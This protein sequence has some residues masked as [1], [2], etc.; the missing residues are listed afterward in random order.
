MAF[1]DRKLRKVERMSDAVNDFY[2]CD[3]CL[4]PGIT[5]PKG[6]EDQARREFDAH[7][8]KDYPVLKN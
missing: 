3:L 8:C 6:G 4:W 1:F 5:V 7:S 2:D